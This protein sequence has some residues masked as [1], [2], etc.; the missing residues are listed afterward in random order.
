MQVYHNTTVSQHSILRIH[1]GVILL[2]K[3]SQRNIDQSR[4][5]LIK[6][7]KDHKL[8]MTT[9]TN[10]KVIDFL[11]VTLDLNTSIRLVQK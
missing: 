10:A 3:T 7:L 8:K 4:K 6:F 11:D 5:E 9:T 1:D 2:C